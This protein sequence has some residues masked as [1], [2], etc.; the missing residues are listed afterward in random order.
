M[1]IRVYRYS[2]L[3]SIRQKYI[4][5]WSLLFPIILGTLF[6]VSFGNINETEHMFH[7]IPVAYVE[8]EEPQKEY[9]ELLKQLEK[10]DELIKVISVKEAEAKQLLEEEKVEGIYWNDKEITL[11]VNKEGISQS[12]LKSIQGQYEQ[13]AR[14]YSNIAVE[15]PEGMQKAAENLK[16]Q[17]NYLKEDG[18]LNQEMDMMMNYFYALIA[19]NCLYGCYL[20]INCVVESKANLSDLAARRV[21]ASTNRFTIM[22]GEVAASITVQ[23]LCTVLGAAYLRYALNI[24]LGEESGRILL[25]ILV[26]SAIGVMTGV[27]MG[28]IGRKEKGLK[29]GVC[30]GFVMMECFLAGLM[31][32]NMY[33]YIE[34]YAPIV[35]HINPAALIVKA[36][37][38]LNIYETYTRYNQC[39]LSLLIITLLL[40]IGSY[41]MVRRERYASL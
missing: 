36:L 16:K 35:N 32:G 39:V 10:E 22:M 3:R 11:T 34:E 12:I 21:A 26:G 13:T 38:S 8:K 29:E 14:A 40:G 6:K 4:I 37:Y 17:W 7:Q 1:F 23:S 30:T 20:G 5:F 15:H 2:L 25:I 27:F 28:S 41:F 18:I 19:M 33:R 31:V 24:K 9:E